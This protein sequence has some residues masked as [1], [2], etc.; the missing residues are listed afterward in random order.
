M[1]RTSTLQETVKGEGLYVKYIGKFAEKKMQP[2]KH[3]KWSK[4][5]PIATHKTENVADHRQIAKHRICAIFG[6]VEID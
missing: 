3:S 5:Q 1:K 4:N 6:L 2:A